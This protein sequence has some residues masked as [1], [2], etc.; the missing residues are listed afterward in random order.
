VS[1]YS[2]PS[3]YWTYS[4]M[5]LFVAGAAFFLR[6][7]LRTGAMGMDEGPKYQMLQDDDRR[8]P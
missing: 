6:R 7:A 5:A 1:D 4:I 3:V 8:I 2:W